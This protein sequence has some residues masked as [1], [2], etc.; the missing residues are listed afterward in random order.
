MKN[1]VGLR[2]SDQFIY[3]MR[4]SQLAFHKTDGAGQMPDMIH[5]AALAE[6]SDHFHVFGQQIFRHMAADK[7][8][9]P[10]DQSFHSHTALLF[11]AA[12]FARPSAP[13]HGFGFDT[14]LSPQK[15]LFSEMP[16]AR[17]RRYDVAAYSEAYP[18]S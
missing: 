11:A 12:S 1:E 8:G 9:D 6:R 4:V 10:R 14:A 3:G 17:L 13:K 7:T 2:V 5:S 18:S 15:R 16:P